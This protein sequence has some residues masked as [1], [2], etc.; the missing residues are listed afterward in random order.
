MN[1]NSDKEEESYG[2][3]VNVVSTFGLMFEDN[4]GNRK[5]LHLNLQKIAVYL[6]FL[7]ISY[8]PMTLAALRMR[9]KADSVGLSGTTALIFS[10]GRVVQTGALTETQ[11]CADAWY[12]AKVFS[13]IFGNIPI[14]IENFH[15][16]NMVYRLF[17][18]YP[19]DLWKLNASLGAKSC[20]RPEGC[21]DAFPACRIREV[22]GDK[23]RLVSLV[24]LSG[25]VVNTGAKNSKEIS[26]M[27]EK[28]IAMCKDFKI[29]E[30]DL[31]ILDE[32]SYRLEDRNEYSKKDSIELL[33]N[34]LKLFIDKNKP[35]PIIDI[36][37]KLLEFS[38][39]DDM[40]NIGY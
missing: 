11:A 23:R 28:I 12:V 5:E 30:K 14:V 19:V 20:Y 34:E 31:C 35:Y 29:D 36:T 18:G 33:N 1:E 15:I 38:L 25:K 2:S 13:R 4:H 40:F 21:S 26:Y 16:T 24:Y 32:N 9:M 3:L 10:T 22:T 6:R 27:E 17:L 39:D 7:G 8:N 37:R